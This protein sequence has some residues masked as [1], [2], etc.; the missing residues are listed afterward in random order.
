MSDSNINE[1]S[2]AIEISPWFDVDNME[3][4]INCPECWGKV[5]MNMVGITF[6]KMV[7]KAAGMGSSLGKLYDILKE[8]RGSLYTVL[9]DGLDRARQD[10]VSMSAMMDDE[11]MRG[12]ENMKAFP[13]LRRE[14][15]KLHQ[16]LAGKIAKEELDPNEIQKKKQANKDFGIYDLSDV[17]AMSYLPEG[18][19]SKELNHECVFKGRH[20]CYELLKSLPIEEIC[21]Y[22]RV[23]GEAYFLFSNIVGMYEKIMQYLDEFGITEEMKDASMQLKKIESEF[24]EI[25]EYALFLCVEC[26][27]KNEFLFVSRDRLQHLFQIKQSLAFYLGKEEEIKHTNPLVL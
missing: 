12:R 27:N 17:L 2:V 25:S 20:L 9:C 4:I 16:E 18:D 21:E 8:E 1:N 10:L 7:V 15:W 14:I 5:K 19:E 11:Y 6:E 3:Y 24:K 23:D 22:L 13:W 26:I